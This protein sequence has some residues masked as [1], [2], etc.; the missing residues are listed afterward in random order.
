M[1][2]SSLIRLTSV[3]LF[4][5]FLLGAGGC[6]QTESSK[7]T[8]DK[9]ASA[10]IEDLLKK[11]DEAISLKEPERVAQVLEQLVVQHPDAPDCR[12]WRQNLASTYLTLGNLEPAYRVYRDY[13]KLYPND[14]FAPE[15][16]YQATFAKYKQTVRMRKEC[17]TLEAQKTIKLCEKYLS[18]PS[19]TARRDEILDIK[20]TCENR[21]TNKEFYI[22]DTYLAHGRT[23]SAKS[24]LETL[25]ATHLPHNAEIEP[26][27]MYAEC[28][29]ARAEQRGADAK[30]I[31]ANLQSKFPESPFVKMAQAQAR[32][33]A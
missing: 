19:N 10:A 3:T 16:H 6:K 1:N 26:Q 8:L 11:R 33:L 13:T 7:T 21:I 12:Q 29:L 2:T 24:R 4:S 30:A 17:D 14:D 23:A 15:A 18:K 31:C 32:G 20:K 28:K 5:L 27:L 9:R 22:F 25:K